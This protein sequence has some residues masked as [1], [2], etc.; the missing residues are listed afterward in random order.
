MKIKKWALLHYFLVL[1]FE[2]SPVI[3]TICA[4]KQKIKKN[5]YSELVHMIGKVN[6]SLILVELPNSL[7]W[8]NI[9]IFLFCYLPVK[10]C[11]L[12]NLLSF[13][14]NANSLM[15][16]QCQC[17][18]IFQIRISAVNYRRAFNTVQ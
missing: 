12:P 5:V 2:K 16:L 15:L 8:F 11:V 1:C 7:Q 4:G 10:H 6:A 18:S 14:Y 3:F 9:N 17:M 13:F